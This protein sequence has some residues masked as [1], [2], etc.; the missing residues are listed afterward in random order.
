MGMSE[1]YGSTDRDAALATL[2]RAVEIGVRHF[3]T[4]DMYGCGANEELLREG[5]GLGSPDGP[6]ARAAAAGFP[7]VV[8]SKFGIVRGADGSA[9]G[10]DGRPAYVRAACEASLRR[11]GL[12]TIDLYYYHRVDPATSIEET[13]GAM[14][15]LVAAGKVRAIGL[16]EV[17]ADQL[18]RACAIHPVAAVQSEYSL[19]TR[20]PETNGV[21]DACRELGVAFV[22]YSPLGRGFLTGRWRGAADLEAGDNRR[23]MERWSDANAA[24]NGRLVKEVAALAV[25]RTEVTSPAQLALAWVLSR[26]EFVH[27]IPG[28]RSI[29]RLEQNWAAA[30]IT[31]SADELARLDVACP[32]GAAQGARYGA[33]AIRSAHATA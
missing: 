14:A 27:A 32:A 12:D 7:L 22:A 18:R 15:E 9:V 25:A 1:F 13:V 2:R 24:A 3:D 31:L 33:R 4:A 30:A 28:T 10:A 23:N 11:L 29:E 5:L 21:L 8:A 16:S 26:G 17:T 19:W 20:D 6:A